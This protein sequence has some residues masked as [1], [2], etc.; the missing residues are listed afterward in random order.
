MGVIIAQSGTQ[1]ISW[2]T[3]LEHFETPKGQNLPTVSTA[4]F[5][6]FKP[7]QGIPISIYMYTDEVGLFG[8]IIFDVLTAMRMEAKQFQMIQIT[9]S[10]PGLKEYQVITLMLEVQ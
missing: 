1:T 6:F 4:R 3:P 8:E 10:A 9:I 2:S 7:T 5:S